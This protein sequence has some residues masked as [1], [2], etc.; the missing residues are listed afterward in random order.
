MKGKIL[1]MK[2]EKE[3]LASKA[4]ELWLKDNASWLSDWIA[5]VVV[6]PEEMAKQSGAV[7]QTFIF[8]IEKQDLF[9]MWKL[10][11][12]MKGIV[13]NHAI[14]G[15]GG[16]EPPTIRGFIHSVGRRPQFGDS[17]LFTAT[18]WN[19]IAM[20]E[21]GTILPKRQM[22]ALITKTAVDFLVG[23]QTPQQ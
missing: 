19:T 18:H 13:L 5:N 23:S 11:A 4:E 9:E 17:A 12:N 7:F 15:A 2:E 22:L 20:V 8:P 10:V 1:D 16:G 3:N 21:I 14:Y 6:I